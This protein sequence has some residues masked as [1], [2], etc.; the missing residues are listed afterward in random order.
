[1]K[2][3]VHPHILI[4]TPAYLVARGVYESLSGLVKYHVVDPVD[5][6]SHV[7]PERLKRMRPSI[8]LLDPSELSPS[9]RAHPHTILPA[10]L[11]IPVV[12]LVTSLIDP[13]ILAAYDGSINIYNTQKQMEEIIDAAL[14]HNEQS[15]S[16]AE[17]TN[18]LS[19][20]E[21]TILCHV[22]RGLSNKEI[23]DALNLS[24]FTVTTHR[25]NITRKLGIRSISGLTIY[26]ILNHLVEPT[27]L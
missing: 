4:V 10:D 27:E 16:S 8:V 21:K 17:K 2:Q 15:A 3:I 13:S 19:S 5:S 23:A 9:E 20:R 24:V 1:M 11:N 26:A 14:Q 22:A 12:A 7:T 6:M 25:K 18:E